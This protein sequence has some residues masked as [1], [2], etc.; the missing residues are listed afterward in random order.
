MNDN[1]HEN[2]WVKIRSYA[3]F[4]NAQ[5]DRIRLESRDIYVYL[6]DYGFEFNNSYE[7]TIH[8]F[9]EREDVQRA[10]FNS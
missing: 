6:P 3:S 4:A 10:R 7:E 5:M 1:N 8:L 2:N 9:V